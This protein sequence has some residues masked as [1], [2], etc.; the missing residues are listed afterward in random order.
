[1][2]CVDI[3]V[4]DRR[5]SYGQVGRFLAVHLVAGLVRVFDLQVRCATLEIKAV[6]SCEEKGASSLWFSR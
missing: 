5:Q 4:P 1:M 6:C 2:G 3:V